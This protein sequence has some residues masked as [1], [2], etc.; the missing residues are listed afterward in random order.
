MPHAAPALELRVHRD[1]RVTQAAP[2]RQAGFVAAAVWRTVDPGWME[3][4]GTY[5][6]TKDEG[7]GMYDLRRD[8]TLVTATLTGAHGVLPASVLFTVPAGFRPA[9]TVRRSVVVD[10]AGCHPRTLEVRPLGMVRLVGEPVGTVNRAE[11]PVHETTM[12]WTAGA[13]VCQRHIWVQARLLQALR[14][15]GLV[16]DSCAEV[17]WTDLASVRSLDLNARGH[18][19][20]MA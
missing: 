15:Q 6:S 12:T 11:P 13:G 4:R 9:Q 18:P 14:S 5:V 17:T 19:P 1:G 10:T 16:R 20:R 3:V 8:G 2:P 7:T